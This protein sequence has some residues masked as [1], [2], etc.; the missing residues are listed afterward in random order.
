MA[1]LN[2]LATFSELRKEILEM[3]G[4]IFLGYLGARRVFSLLCTDPYLLAELLLVVYFYQRYTNCEREK[5]KVIDM[6][7]M[8][9]LVSKHG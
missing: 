8:L 7:Y 2:P 3:R 6:K 9:T 4:R 1:A 5:N